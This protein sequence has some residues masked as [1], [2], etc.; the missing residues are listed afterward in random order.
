[1]ANSPRGHSINFRFVAHAVTVSIGMGVQSW[2]TDRRIN[3]AMAPATVPN[4]RK[5]GHWRPSFKHFRSRVNFTFIT[6]GFALF[7]SRCPIRRLIC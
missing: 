6:R 4:G 1:M 5:S 2:R 7:G 3:S